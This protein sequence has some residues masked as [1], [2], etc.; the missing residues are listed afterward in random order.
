MG[1]AQDFE[2]LLIEKVTEDIPFPQFTIVVARKLRDRIKGIKLYAHS[3]AFTLHFRYGVYNTIDFLNF[4][5]EQGLSGVEINL[6][7]GGEKSLASMS[8]SELKKVKEKAREFGLEILLDISGT[9]RDEID[10]VVK[11]AKILG[12]QNIRVYNLHGGYVQDCIRDCV[13]DLKYACKIAEQNGL[14]FAIES[15][16]A[17]KSHELAYVVKEV[18]SDRLG[19]LFD[20]GNM[21]NA[22]EEPLAALKGM[23]DHIWWAHIKDVKIESDRDG[24]AQLGV[25]DGTGDLP[26]LRML[27]ELLMLGDTEPQIKIFALQQ[28]NG[29]KS[30]AYRFSDDG[31]NPEIPTREPSYTRENPRLS[32]NENLHVEKEN[33]IHQVNQIKGLFS[34]L[35][36]MSERKLQSM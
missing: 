6:N 25:R 13:A 28:V 18:N 20:F 21:I 26:Q 8:E 31:E 33:A 3:Y 15:H 7:Y 4:A 10:R 32:R 22:Y 17:M 24:Y 16:E 35:M 11:V 27:Y 5:S 23:S 19:I 34:A 29:Y 1:K 2:K 36:E 30:P 14:Y 12:V 9:E